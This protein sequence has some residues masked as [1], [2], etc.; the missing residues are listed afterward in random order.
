MNTVTGH[1]GPGTSLARPAPRPRWNLL[2]HRMQ[3][4]IGGAVVL[5][6]AFW[7][8]AMVLVAVVSTRVEIEVSGWDGATQIVRWFVGAIGVY[9]TAVHLP[10]YVA[11]GC[12]RRDTARQLGVFGALYAPLAAALVV[13]GFV[14]ERGVYFLAGWPQVVDTTNLVTG[15]T[16]L[17]GLFV[18]YT[19]VFAVWLAGGAMVGAGY[20]RR[21]DLGTALLIPGVGLVL[22]VETAIGGSERSF[23]AVP[24]IG[25]FGDRSVEPGT[26]LLVGLVL[27]AVALTVAAT[28]RIVRDLPLKSEPA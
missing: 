2:R 28:W 25:A 18:Q 1:A 22:L 9:L 11:H 4:D 10:L 20:Y 19:L 17:V 23:N 21:G 6:A 7:V 8:A 12:T 24:F 13:V 15:A 16:D 5:A 27:V 26:G 14:L 3:V